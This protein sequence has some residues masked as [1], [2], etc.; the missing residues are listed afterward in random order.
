MTRWLHWVSSAALV[1][2][3]AGTAAQAEERHH[4]G[5]HGRRAPLSIPVRDMPLLTPA[6]AQEQVFPLRYPPFKKR[7]PGSPLPRTA[8]PRL[9]SGLPPI[10]PKAPVQ[11][12]DFEGLGSGFS[13]FSAA[14]TPP[15][16]DGAV[17]RTQYVQLVNSSFAVFDKVSGSKLAGPTLTKNL[18]STL[19]APNPCI[20]TNN[21]DGIVLYDHLANRWIITQFANA[22]AS[23]GPYYECVAI[24]QTGDATGQ[25]FLYFFTFQDFSGTKVFP[26]YPKVGIWPDAYYFSYNGFTNSGASGTFSAAILCALDRSSMLNGSASLRG[27]A[28][29][30]GPSLPAGENQV[31][32]THSDSDLL[33]SD[34][35]GPTPPPSGSPD[36]YVE[37]LDPADLALFRF[38]VDFNTLTNSTLNG[39]NWV[40]PVGPDPSPSAVIALAGV[41]GASRSGNVVTITTT[42]PHGF[43]VGLQVTIAGVTDTS[44]NGTFVIASTPT[45]TTFT[46]AQ[47]ALDG[48]SG[49]GTATE[50]R[51]P[52][53]VVPVT[54]FVPTCDVQNTGNTVCIPQANGVSVDSLSDRVMHRFAYRNFGTHESLVVN[55]AVATSGTS[56]SGVRWYEI[57]NPNG[58]DPSITPSCTPALCVTVADW[59]TWAPD[60]NYRWMG[61]VA[62]DRFG[63]LAAG[64]SVSSPL[65]NPAV[66]YATRVSPGNLG[67]EVTVVSGTASEDN[68]VGG[69]WGDYSAM[70]VDPEDDCTFWYT[71]EYYGTTGSSNWRTR[72]V[73]F[74]MPQ[75]QTTPSSISVTPDTGAGNTRT[76]SFLYADTGGANKIMTA[77]GLINA[78]NSLTSACAF[79]YFT[80]SSSTTPNTLQIY[81]NGGAPGGTLTPGSGSVSNSQCTINGAGTT[82]ASAGNSM[83]LNVSITFTTPSFDGPKNI[84]LSVADSNTSTPFQPFGAWTVQ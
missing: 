77:S 72:I 1:C 50:T 20:T 26:D 52:R 68:T 21:G 58:A 46:Y 3:M 74:R 22:A 42:T 71:N 11:L 67:N 12:L 38:H 54:P 31:C 18:W 8:A 63:N 30:S 15:D 25:F 64:Y 81:T 27:V 10:G 24:S 49:N 17:G 65:M 61:S 43:I 66:A 41:P 78:S 75:C 2:A 62:M 4:G 53:V 80:A 7:V 57:Q 39:I 13:G 14:G 37:W 19:T 9:E 70:S 60:S 45:S 79:Q 51:I 29:P 28:G 47:T 5:G 73:N 34:L 23:S 33:P 6:D 36:H 55:H 40:S 56:G 84:Y 69:R 83:V 82:V 16:T 32:F 76:F 48:S 59:G 35:D 44:F